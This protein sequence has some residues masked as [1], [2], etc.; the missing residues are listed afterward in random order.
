MY[1][2][3]V[4][5]VKEGQWF[6]W[7]FVVMG[8]IL[9]AF[10]LNGAITVNEKAKFMDSK[11]L[12]NKVEVDAKENIFGKVSYSTL[13]Y[14]E[15]EDVEYVCKSVLR[16]SGNP[17]NKNKTV[18]YDSKNPSDCTVGYFKEVNKGLLLL[19]FIPL[20]LL[21]IGGVNLLKI[22]KR[23]KIINNLNKNGKLVKNLKYEL[24]NT[25]VAINSKVIKKPCIEYTLPSGVIVPLYGDAR[26][27]NIFADQDGLIDL[28][29]DERNPKNYFMDYNINRIGGNLPSDYF[30]DPNSNKGNTYITNEE[31]EGEKMDY[32]TV[33]E[34]EFN[35]LK[36]EEKD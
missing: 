26:F 4:K 12:S 7:V 20:L 34:E 28:I 1:D 14:Y 27:D 13:Y 22:S 16:N 31:A 17:G 5:F 18:Y 30:I 11:I 25:N 9:T 6:W 24:V 3:N 19:L 36:E 23:L 21:I 35:R 33:S 29:I 8:I 2:I 32:T 15:V 10:F